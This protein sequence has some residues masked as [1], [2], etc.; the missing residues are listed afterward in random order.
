MLKHWRTITQ[1]MF[2]TPNS[3]G[4]GGST[5]ASTG[6]TP[7][8]APS[9]PASASA[10]LE[11]ASTRLESAS[12]TD[13]AATG[14]AKPAGTTGTATSTPANGNQP[15]RQDTTPE[16]RIQAAVANARQELMARVGWAENLN[17]DEVQE[18][19][20]MLRE[21]SRDPKAYAARIMSEIQEEEPE[22]DP[23]PDL[24]SQ[25]GR[26]RAFSNNA[27]KKLMANLEKRLTSRFSKEYKPALE[28]TQNAQA[29]ERLQARLAEARQIG[30]Q[31]L[32]HLRTRPHFK[33]NEKLISEK[34]ATMNPAYRRK[35]GSVAA[36]HMAYDAVMQEHVLPMLEKNV[37]ERVLAGY[38]KSANASSGSIDPATGTGAK[39][40]IKDGD[41]DALARR[42]EELNAG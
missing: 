29:N 30:T 17:R 9:A 14:V 32:E 28:Y 8:S 6:T 7:Q 19:V 5:T 36:L 16:S 10:A 15:A 1:L 27:V 37:E 40:A 41:L 35:V 21:L 42:M 31:A 13:S 11:S 3:G 25:D 26:V 38:R 2:E 34:L 22:P 12:S 4:T 33:E 39:P 18:A 23:E 20:E 24:V